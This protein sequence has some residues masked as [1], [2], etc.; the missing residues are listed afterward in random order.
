MTQALAAAAGLSED[1][2][3]DVALILL[4][5][6][7]LA[8]SARSKPA[9]CHHDDALKDRAQD[10]RKGRVRVRRRLQFLQRAPLC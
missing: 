3:V 7:R 5:S 2:L 10:G 9:P 4:I 1:V 6:W 8:A